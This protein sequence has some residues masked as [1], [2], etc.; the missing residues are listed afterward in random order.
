MRFNFF[1]TEDFSKGIVNRLRIPGIVALELSKSPGSYVA[2]FVP[3][4]KGIPASVQIFSC[5]KELQ[6]QPVARR[7]FFQCSSVQLSWNCGSTGLLVLVQS[8]FD[9]TNQSYYGVTKLNYLTIDGTHTGLVPLNKEGP[10][11]DVRWSYSGKDFAVV[12]GCI[13]F[14]LLQNFAIV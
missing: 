12:Y 7:S 10:V 2:A 3:E 14:F 6:S 4:S 8:D 13:L 1:D 5:N 11:H 9:K